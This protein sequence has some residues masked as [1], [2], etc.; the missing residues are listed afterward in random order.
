MHKLRQTGNARL[1]CSLAFFA[2]CPKKS[3]NT[4]V[5]FSLYCDNAADAQD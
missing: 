5:V 3:E 1:L 4:L 2:D